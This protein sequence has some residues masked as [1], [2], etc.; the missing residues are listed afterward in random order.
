MRRD[1]A[2]G[3]KPEALS[4]EV[5]AVIQQHSLYGFGGAS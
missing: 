1:I 4:N 3:K 2:A 5:W